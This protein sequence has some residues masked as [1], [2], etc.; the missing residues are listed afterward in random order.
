MIFVIVMADTDVFVL[1]VKFPEK[2]EKKIRN[3]VGKRL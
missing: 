2:R 3:A 1:H